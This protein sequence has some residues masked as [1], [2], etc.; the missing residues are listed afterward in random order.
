MP[1]PPSLEFPQRVDHANA[2]TVLADLTNRLQQVG[3]GAPVVL[4]LKALAHF[5][6]SALSVLLALRRHAVT[7]GQSL[8][9]TEWPH[10]LLYLVEAYGLKAALQADTD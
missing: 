2:S 4:G 6:S 5:D 9:I 8:Q 3:D 1:I 7:S 10:K